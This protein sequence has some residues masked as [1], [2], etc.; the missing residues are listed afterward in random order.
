MRFL[1]SLSICLILLLQSL[2]ANSES[3]EFN[4]K[5]YKGGR[6]TGG[7]NGRPVDGA[8]INSDNYYPNA[9]SKIE[10]AQPKETQILP[11]EP[12]KKEPYPERQYA[13]DD[14]KNRA[15]EFLNELSTI[16]EYEKNPNPKIEAKKEALRT[17][18]KG[19]LDQ[20]SSIEGKPYV[21]SVN[22]KI[23]NDA[24]RLFNDIAV[25]M[26]EIE[27]TNP[28]TDKEYKARELKEKSKELKETIE[29]EEQNSGLK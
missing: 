13:R 14:I 25:F 8:D 29:A 23:R 10:V 27:K 6:P 16:G 1:N 26:D 4:G 22:D 12:Q 24:K 17:R 20:I 28:N 15:V 11:Q 21:A 2:S 9:P 7:E 19:L 5:T 3:Y 18:V